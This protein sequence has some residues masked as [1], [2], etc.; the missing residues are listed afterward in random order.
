MDWDDERIEY[1]DGLRGMAIVLIVLSHLVIA[2]FP[3]VITQ[4]P[5]DAHTPFDMIFGFAPLG[6][7]W[8][9]DFG[10]CLFAILS[11]YALSRFCVRSQISFPAKLLRRYLRLALPILVTSTLAWLL[12]ALQ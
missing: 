6:F 9:A 2:L 8:N 1:L 11:G 3:S 4:S 12:L 10:V 5:P 7:L